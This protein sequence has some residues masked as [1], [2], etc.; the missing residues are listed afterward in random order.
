MAK[1]K[2]AKTHKTNWRK[3]EA[4]NCKKNAHEEETRSAID[5]C[6]MQCTTIDNEN[7]CA[8]L[9]VGMTNLYLIYMHIQISCFLT[10]MT[11]HTHHSFSLLVFF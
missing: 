11:T 10:T 2:K 7:T 5:G 3:K 9:F 6:R 1:D 8:C 4:E